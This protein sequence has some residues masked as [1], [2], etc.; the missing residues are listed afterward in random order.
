MHQGQITHSGLTVQKNAHMWQYSTRNNAVTK[1]ADLL[2]F[3][4]SN[5]IHTLPALWKTSLNILPVSE[6][7]QL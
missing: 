4:I 2:P 7:L 6:L 5:I 1:V 3:A